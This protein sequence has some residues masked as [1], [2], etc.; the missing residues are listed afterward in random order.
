MGV[1]NKPTAAR[2]PDTTAHLLDTKAFFA[3]PC[4]MARVPKALFEGNCDFDGNNKISVVSATT[5]CGVPLFWHIASCLL[6]RMA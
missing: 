3:E 4:S 1:Y 2:F 6:R 5:I